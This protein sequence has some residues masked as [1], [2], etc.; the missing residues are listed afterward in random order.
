MFCVNCGKEIKDGSQFC[1]HCGK[2]VVAIKPLVETNV[3]K[4][5]L[6]KEASIKENDPSN[7]V[8]SSKE[9]YVQE[10]KSDSKSFIFW[11]VF[12]VCIL[13]VSIG[14]FFG[15]RVLV[16]K[17]MD[18]KTESVSI[19]PN[20][21]SE[22]SLFSSRN[23]DEEFEEEIEIENE[24][25]DEFA[26]EQ[27]TAE[28]ELWNDNDPELAKPDEQENVENSKSL[29]ESE[30]LDET[31]TEEEIEEP[32]EIENDNTHRF[33]LPNS[34]SEYLT[35]KDLRGFSAEECRFARN[36]IYAR[37]GRKFNDEELQAYFDR[38]DW[39]RGRIDPDDFTE[40]MLNE[41]ELYNRDF[42]VEFEEKQGYR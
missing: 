7:N 17:V 4:S 41:Y 35:I 10:E 24:N 39:Y 33:I 15:A 3:Q 1:V 11:P 27:D 36:E 8:V 12:I 29:Q 34:D 14:L 38:Q 25:T 32:K 37:H 13:A 21:L 18:S 40:D 23:S 2:K 28:E 30:E 6:E 42:I 22:T 9:T 31:E 26:V 5:I 20:K 19:N 16:L